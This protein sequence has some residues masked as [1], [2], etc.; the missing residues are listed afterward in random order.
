MDLRKLS[1]KA[2][3]G[4]YRSCDVY[5]ARYPGGGGRALVLSYGDPRITGEE[6]ARA[7]VN[8]PG[9]SEHLADD[10]VVIKEYSGHEGMLAALVEAGIV[11][12]TGGRV[13]FGFVEGQPVARVVI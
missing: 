13:S 10:E 5:E 11:E 7:T 2:D 8:V 1:V 12:D 9:V 6:V 3:F 4:V